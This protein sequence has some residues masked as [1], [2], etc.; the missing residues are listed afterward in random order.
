MAGSFS[1]SREAKIKSKLSEFNV[2]AHISTP[3]HVAIKNAV[4]M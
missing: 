4:T 3:S 1:M 2:T